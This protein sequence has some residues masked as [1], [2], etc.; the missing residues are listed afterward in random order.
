MNLTS[1]KM[2]IGILAVSSVVA[3]VVNVARPTPLPWIRE[4]LP[5]KPPVAASSEHV[6]S[7]PAKSPADVN[8]AT[9]E[10]AK[11]AESGVT[12]EMVLSYLQNGTAHF[13]DAREDHEWVE[14]HL[15]GAIHIPA[16]A[17]YQNIERIVHLVP[18]NEKVIVYCTGGQCEASHHVA[19]ALDRDF[20]F[21]DVSI[22]TK[23]WEE[24][25]KVEAFKPFIAKGEEQ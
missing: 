10:P 21:S 8:P 24:I 19:E 9:P 23:G 13:V 12:K 7:Q 16:S 18:P 14:G 17:I 25:E 3:A 22:Y 20:H 4:P 2:L 1:L 11:P 15:R 6:A 5:V